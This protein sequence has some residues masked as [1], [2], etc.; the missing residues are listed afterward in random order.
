MSMRKRRSEAEWCELIEQQAQSG[1]S[2]LDF[3][4]QHGLLA[5]TFYR[6]RKL[7]RRKGLVPVTSPFIQVQPMPAPV[8]PLHPGAVLQYRE[9]RLQLSA[10]TDPSW[11][12]QLMKTLS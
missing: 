9:S 3:C 4:R 6:Q 7:L 10:G 8:M 2:G 12:T 11:L 1:L 5:K